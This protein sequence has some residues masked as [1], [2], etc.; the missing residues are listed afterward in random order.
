[1]IDDYIFNSYYTGEKQFYDEL[2]PYHDMSL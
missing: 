2:K 1:M